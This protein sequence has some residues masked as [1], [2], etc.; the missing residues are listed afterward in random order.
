[1]NVKKIKKLEVRRE[2]LGNM[3]VKQ[4][5]KVG[6]GGLTDTTCH[7]CGTCALLQNHNRSQVKRRA[8]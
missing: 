5:E 6:G 3:T 7:S 2:R 4:L 1:M 8:K